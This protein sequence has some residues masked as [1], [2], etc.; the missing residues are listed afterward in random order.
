[1]LT[2][3]HALVTGAGR[4]I[5]AAIAERLAADGARLTLLG[6]TREPLEALAGRLGDAAAGLVVCDVT[7][8][9]AVAEAV[10]SLP[11]VDILINNAGQA[12]SAPLT[13]TSDSDWQRMLAVNLTAPF[14]CARAVLP[15]MLQAGWGRIVTVASTAGL[16]G[17]PYVTAYTAAKHGVV[18]LTRALALEVATRGVTVNAV[19]PGFTETD[20]LRDSVATIMQRTG[21]SEAEARATLAAHNPQGRF[22]TPE[23]VASAVS[24]LVSPAAGAL[25]GLALPVSGGEVA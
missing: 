2:D 23:D 25:T 22:I 18:G 24:W 10:A 19:C 13:R 16:R 11:R 14:A 7:D 9:M 1:M 21:R 17:Y 15:G 4:G 5:G 6:R 3:R 12:F 8:T 20:L